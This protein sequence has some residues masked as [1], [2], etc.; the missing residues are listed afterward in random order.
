MKGIP[1]SATYA[2]EHV[3]EHDRAAVI[4]SKLCRSTF[5]SQFAFL[6][7]IVSICDMDWSQQSDRLLCFDLK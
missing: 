3:N 4:L 5:K 2:L 6:H 7:T 1:T